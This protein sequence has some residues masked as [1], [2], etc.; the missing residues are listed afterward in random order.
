MKF[1]CHINME[2]SASIKATKYTHK[3]IY[4]GRDRTTHEMIDVDKVKE[5]LDSKCILLVEAM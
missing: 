3:Y 4:K 2:I 1:Q 5:H